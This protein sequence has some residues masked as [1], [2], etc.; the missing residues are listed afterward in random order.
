MPD[1]DRPPRPNDRVPRVMLVLP[2][3]KDIVRARWGEVLDARRAEIERF[4][5]AAFPPGAEVETWPGVGTIVV[6]V[7]LWSRH[8]A[9][10]N[11][12]GRHL[13]VQGG[14]F[15]GVLPAPGVV[16]RQAELDAIGLGNPIARQQDWGDKVIVGVLD[17]GCNP[18]QEFLNIVKDGFVWVDANGN[19]HA[20]APRDLDRR[21][22]GTQVSE[23][24]AG[25]VSGAAPGIPL[26]IAAVLENGEGN[27]TQI[28]RGLEW[29]VTTRFREWGEPGCDVINASIDIHEMNE[30]DR[31]AITAQV[32]NADGAHKLIV[33][34][35]GNKGGDP[36]L[37]PFADRNDGVAV[38]A[39]SPPPGS[40]GNWIWASSNKSEV[41]LTP[42]DLRKPDVCAPGL[43][44]SLAAPMVTG[45]C[46]RLIL[47]DKTA[48]LRDNSGELRY[49]LFV[50][51][52]LLGIEKLPLG[53]NCAG[54]RAR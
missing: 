3:L 36:R 48:T 26:A 6:P 50:E 23:T 4:I 52:V 28:A 32:E 10:V 29:L 46:A 40:V 25:M 43:C 31:Q 47:H 5:A 54:L 51:H 1:P 34:A 16:D 8:L 49:K 9:A 41:R 39:V 13:V 19:A 37:S 35:V 27:A 18:A 33:C 24:L 2:Q 20:T 30:P 42:V 53:L 12:A 15:Q 21:T 11:R 7:D 22:H 45:V 17:S 14:T 38:G 44:S